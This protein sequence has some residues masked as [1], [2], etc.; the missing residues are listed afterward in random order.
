MLLHLV[1]HSG[2]DFANATRELSKVMDGATE[3]QWKELRKLLKFVVD[4][5]WKGLRIAPDV[6]QEN[7]W[8]MKGFSDSNYC[9]DKETH[10][11]ITGFIINLVGVPISGK[12]KGQQGV[13]LSAT[14][15]EYVAVSEATREIK[16]II[17]VLDSLKLQVEYPITVH[18]DN[19]GAI[20]L[21]NDRTT[22]K[23]TKHIDIRHHFVREFIE[24]VIVKI[25]FVK[26]KDN[27]ADVFTKN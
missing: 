17:Q 3:G 27:N 7:T 18:M 11:N 10:R 23:R 21:A 20:F 8:A 4:M 26:S 25:I 5:K 24:D 2:P 15:A 1:K 6:N 22:N 16:F 9:A 14:E 13:V 12:S 19:V